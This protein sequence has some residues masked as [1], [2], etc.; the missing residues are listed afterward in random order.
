[1]SATTTAPPHPP[2]GSCAV[3]ALSAAIAAVPASAQFKRPGYA[4]LEAVEE[5]EGTAVEKAI[6]DSAALMVG[7]DCPDLR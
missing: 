6:K 2:V 1:M 5:R 4:F 3:T 7:A